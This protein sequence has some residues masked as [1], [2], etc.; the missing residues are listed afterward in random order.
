MRGDIRLA[1]G[2]R[3]AVFTAIHPNFY[4]DTAPYLL[5]GVEGVM[6]AATYAKRSL[7]YFPLHFGFFDNS[8][9]CRTC[10]CR[11]S[12]KRHGAQRIR[13]AFDSERQRSRVRV[14]VDGRYTVAE[15]LIGLDVCNG[16]SR[17]VLLG[18]SELLNLA[19]Q[20]LHLEEEA[21]D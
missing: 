2:N 19:V 18:L 16:L 3:D 4:P 9:Q 6:R 11:P 10:F 13:L 5:T 17:W 14:L 1:K 20:R 12:W 15:F 7:F 8:A 21:V